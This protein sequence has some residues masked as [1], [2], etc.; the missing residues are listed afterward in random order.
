MHSE[1]R[2]EMKGKTGAYRSKTSE[3]YI[4]LTNVYRH[5]SSVKRLKPIC[6]GKFP[7][8]LIQRIRVGA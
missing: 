1:E 2:E 5:L 7:I 4:R 6:G 8:E 3:F